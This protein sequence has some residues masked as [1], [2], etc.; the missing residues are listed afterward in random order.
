M[1]GCSVIYM[2]IAKKLMEGVLQKADIRIGGERPWDIQVHDTRLYRR[3]ILSGSLGLGDSYMD[4]WW[5]AEDLTG[6]IVRIMRSGADQEVPGQN[7]V[8]FFMGAL[9]A[10]VNLQSKGRAFIVGERHYDLGNDL[11]EA[12]LD[13]SLTYTCA[14]WKDAATLT[15]AQR[16][17]LDLVCKKLKLEKGM[18]VL[19]IGSGWGSFAAHAARHYG[20]SV[21]GITVSK[22]QAAFAREKYADLPVEFELLDYRDVPK[23]YA[24][25]FDRVVS[26]GM[27]EH[28]GPKNYR[29][30]MK[31]AA[32]ALRPD[33]LFLLHTIG[34]HEGGADAWI[35][36]HIF[37]GG[38]IPNLEQV[39]RAVRGAFICE[40]L[41]NFGPYYARTLQAWRSNFD[42]HY[43][44]LDHG[45]Y[46]ERFRRMWR[47]YLSVSEA[48][49]DARWLQLWQIVLSKKLAGGYESVR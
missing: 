10:V 30:Y 37:P 49:F 35:S 22:E 13:P 8:K 26:I 17:K 21:V 25:A 7:I 38:V 1:S 16:A 41:H 24:G 43:A 48:G 32:S 36:K 15:E 44:S 28:V 34:G 42:A 14:Y 20:V 29:D 3:V 40:D 5:D 46:D 47:Y 31:V 27:F 4:G 39:A 11:Y 9:N 23:K 19:D 12:M 2:A 45:K 33:G 6:L 18:R